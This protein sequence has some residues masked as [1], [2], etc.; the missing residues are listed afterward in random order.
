[1]VISLLLAFNQLI[2][3]VINCNVTLIFF[4]MLHDLHA[5]QL[6]T[7]LT[8]NTGVLRPI[9]EVTVPKTGIHAGWLATTV[10]LYF[11]LHKA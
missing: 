4:T 6:F 10:V 5:I 11:Y 9:Q 1:M 7:T 2:Y 3:A 8:R